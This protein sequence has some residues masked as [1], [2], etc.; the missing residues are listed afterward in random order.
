MRYIHIPE[1]KRGRRELLPSTAKRVGNVLLHAAGSEGRFADKRNALLEAAY[2]QQPG[3]IVQIGAFDGRLDDPLLDFLG[4]QPSAEAVLVEPQGTPYAA[5][6]QRYR[7]YSNVRCVNRAVGSEDGYQSLYYA[8]F[9]RA[10]S[11]WGRAIASFDKSHI[12]KVMRRHPLRRFAGYTTKSERVPTLTLANLFAELAVEPQM[13][14]A[15][16]CDTEGSDAAIV[17]QLLD[18]GAAPA[19]LQYE[20]LHLDQTEVL[21]LN[22]QLV[23]LG[24]SLDFSH[25]DVLAHLPDLAT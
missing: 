19:I 4:R 9:G 1:A 10:A 12:E 22:E 18:T 20:Y 17:A 23:H 24:Y 2:R 25:K 14:T 6:Q 5:L 3:L 8:D 16:F 15:F 7:N 11:P 21:V 13:V